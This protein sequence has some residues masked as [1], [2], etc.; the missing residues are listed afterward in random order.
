MIKN[1]IFDMGNVLLSF[2]PHK[3]VDALPLNDKDKRI[4]YNE[5]YS[6][7]KNSYLDRGDFTEEA[8]VEACVNT[9]GEKFRTHIEELVYNWSKD[10]VAVPGMKELIKELKDKG[11][12]IYLLSNAGYR[13][14][15]YWE[16]IPG[17]EYFDGTLISCDVKTLKP[18]PKMYEALFKKFKL[19]PSE[20]LFIDDL[21]INIYGAMEAGMEGIVFN[22]ETEE[23]RA[24]L[25]KRKIL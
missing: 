20:C 12:K 19:T 24:E 9:I 23:L 11:Y 22:D 18:E 25:I 14:H 17:H 8:Y 1:M 5:V 6:S 21:P 4:I 16:K 10:V 15:E 7:W 2:S 13:Q 3:Y